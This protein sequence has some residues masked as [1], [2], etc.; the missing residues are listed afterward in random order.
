MFIDEGCILWEK[1]NAGI[2]PGSL[3]EAKLPLE[4]RNELSKAGVRLGKN[5]VVESMAIVEASEVGEGTIVESGAKV[6]VGCVIGKVRYRLVQRQYLQDC[7]PNTT[8]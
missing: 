1:G 7:E 5:V 4:V 2:Q 6:G 8:W 3:D